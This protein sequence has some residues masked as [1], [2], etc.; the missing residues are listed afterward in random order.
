MW[1]TSKR[2]QPVRTA[3]CLAM[4]PGART[5]QQPSGK[6]NQLAPRRRVAVVERSFAF[7]FHALL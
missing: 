3:L 2:P 7:H 4:T 1:L 5:R 6:G